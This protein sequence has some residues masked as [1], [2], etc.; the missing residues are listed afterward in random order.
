VSNF[1]CPHCLSADLVPAARAVSVCTCPFCE[2]QFGALGLHRQF[3]ICTG[4]KILLG[5]LV[6]LLLG[7]A[8]FVRLLVAILLACRCAEEWM[9]KEPVRI[10]KAHGGEG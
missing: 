3:G 2:A 4:L 5:F 10:E 6:G 7:L 1:I 8:T 9:L